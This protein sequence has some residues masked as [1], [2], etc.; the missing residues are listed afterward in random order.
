MMM[1]LHMICQ[2]RLRDHRNTT[3]QTQWIEENWDLTLQMIRYNGMHNHPVWLSVVEVDLFLNSFIQLYQSTRMMMPNWSIHYQTQWIEEKWDLT[4]QMIRYYGMP[5]NPVWLIEVEEDLFLISFTQLYQ[6]TRMMM[7]HWNNSDQTQWIEEKWD[8][9]LQMIW[10]HGMHYHPIWLIEV[11]EDLFLTPFFQIYQSTR[12]MTPN[13]N[14][15]HQSQR[16]QALPTLS[17]QMTLLIGMPY[18]WY[19]TIAMISYLPRYSN[20]SWIRFNTA[21]GASLNA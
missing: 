14:N 21:D 2:N 6:S 7:L 1:P 16:F 10:Q 12:M 9:T 17:I 18:C 13:R 20:N 19:W 15:S 4:L 3:D 8:L 5:Y 11:E